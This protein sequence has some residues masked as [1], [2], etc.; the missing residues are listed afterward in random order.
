M[1]RPG[2]LVSVRNVTEAR[3]ALAGGAD[4]IDVKEPARGPL[5]R[6]DDEVIEA[7]CEVVAAEATRKHVVSAA[8]GELIDLQGTDAIEWVPVN[9]RSVSQRGAQ[10]TLKRFAHSQ[11]PAFAFHKVG[12][13][14]A[15]CDWRDR[16]A[17]WVDVTR[18]S[19]VQPI[20]AA[21]A[22]ASQVD[23]PDLNDVA[24]WAVEN[25][26]GLL[27]DTAV[28][29]GWTLFDHVDAA[30]VG[31]MVSRVRAA[32]LVVALAGSLR[33]DSFECAIDIGPTYVAVRGAACGSGDRMNG[34]EVAR[35]EAL[36]ARVRGVRGER[37]KP[38]AATAGGRGGG[39][40][41]LR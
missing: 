12:L 2:L 36:V 18:A 19:A 20:V 1:S 41:S 29:D 17:D 22:D 15:P 37:A 38:Q 11:A 40:R 32:G 28:K 27:I 7:V 9:E 10:H 33:G 8:L 26:V 5:G 16:L 13:A 21:Y 6:A 23:A 3:A 24:A 31:R 4:V 14:G 34:V 30:R 39:S 35:V 25:G